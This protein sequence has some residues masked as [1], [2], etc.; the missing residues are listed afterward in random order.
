MHD[1]NQKH[2]LR[3]EHGLK[4]SSFNVS[5]SIYIYIWKLECIVAGVEEVDIGQKN[6]QRQGEYKCLKLYLLTSFT[7]DLYTISHV[8]F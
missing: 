8:S 4:Y 3:G 7:F 2:L 1:L 6:A 5:A